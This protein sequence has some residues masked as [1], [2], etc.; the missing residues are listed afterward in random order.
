M[1]DNEDICGLCGEPGAD[2]MAHPNHWP[3]E[4]VP[5][6]PMVH[7]EREDDECRRAHAALSEREREAF[8]RT[9]R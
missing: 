1:D 2:K 6:G 4:R 9:V 7:A 5:D 3:G 8:L